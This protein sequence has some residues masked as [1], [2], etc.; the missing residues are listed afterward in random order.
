VHLLHD[1]ELLFSKCYPALEG[2]RFTAEC[3]KRDYLTAGFSSTCEG[4]SLGAGQVREDEK[5]W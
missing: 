3:F 1:G 5:Q 4:R 2:A